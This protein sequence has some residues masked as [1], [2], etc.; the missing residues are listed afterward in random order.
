MEYKVFQ[1]D[2]STTL[3]ETKLKEL[4]ELLNDRWTVFQCD[5]VPITGGGA[6]P[7]RNLGILVYLLK[8]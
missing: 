6:S 5:R 1:I 8:K 4:E 2:F 7:Y 3:Y